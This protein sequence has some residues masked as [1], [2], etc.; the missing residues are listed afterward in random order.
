MKGAEASLYGTA[1]V[2]RMAEWSMAL[3]WKT[4]SARLTVTP[5]H[6]VAQRVQRVT[7]SWPCCSEALRADVLDEYP[8]VLADAGV[9]T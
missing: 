6:L 9:R 4:I 8:V 5:K 1:A 7:P 3:A 2:F